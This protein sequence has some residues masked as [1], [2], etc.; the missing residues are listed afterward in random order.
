MKKTL[1]ILLVAILAISSVIGVSA[2]VSSTSTP[3]NVPSLCQ[4]ED[5]LY[6]IPDF[7]GTW[8][9]TTNDGCSI[10]VVRQD[11]NQVDLT[12]QSCNANATK[13]ATSR[14]RLE[15][16]VWIENDGKVFG[17]AR[18]NY[19]DSYGS[20]GRGSILITDDKITLKLNEEFN[21][22]AAWSIAPCAG[23]YY[24]ATKDVDP[25]EADRFNNLPENQQIPFGQVEVPDY[26]GLYMS[27]TNG[28]ASIE[29][30]NQEGTDMDLVI[31]LHNANYTKIATANVFVSLDITPND[32]N[33]G[34]EMA[35]ADFEYCDSFGSCGTG[36]VS[37]DDEGNLYLDL[38][39]QHTGAWT[40]APAEGVFVR[41]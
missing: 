11:D 36:T 38:D 9:H 6:D 21:P 32:G 19:A 27:T 26:E 13:I 28:G 20:G 33:T 25:N 16:N 17:D 39:E 18:F 29:I 23:E 35:T 30:L 15:L 22:C 24:L 10:Q 2:A 40:I 4:T 8:K 7:T 5:D 3:D 31:E 34:V 1:S 37:F 14:L 41:V 12:I